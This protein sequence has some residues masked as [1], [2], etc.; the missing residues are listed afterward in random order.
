MDEGESVMDESEFPPLNEIAKV[1]RTKFMG[2]GASSW[3]SLPTVMKKHWLEGAEAVVEL[4]REHRGHQDL[5]QAS[6]EVLALQEEREQAIRAEL[7]NL[8]FDLGR[9]RGAK[10]PG[11]EPKAPRTT[12]Q[13]NWGETS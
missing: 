4:I 3:G 8:A 12:G 2:T 13:D 5:R 9:D 11:E 7:S 1:F 10:E 6:R